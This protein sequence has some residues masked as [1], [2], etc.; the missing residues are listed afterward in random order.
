MRLIGHALLLLLALCVVVAGI[1]GGLRL[2]DAGR[3]LQPASERAVGDRVVFE[4][5]PGKPMRFNVSNHQG[6]AVLRGFVVAGVAARARAMPL[7]VQIEVLD[8]DARRLRVDRRFLELMASDQAPAPYG[9]LAGSADA[10]VWLL[11]EE[12]IDLGSHPQ[13]REIRVQPV[14]ADAAIAEV[15]WRA[16]IEARLGDDA[17]RLRY[18]RLGARRRDALTA[19]WVTPASLI[20]PQ[21]KR[22]LMRRQRQP[23]GPLGQEGTDYRVRRVLRD[24]FERQRRGYARTESREFAIGPGLRV[25]VQVSAPTSVRIRSAATAD[26]ALTL[27]QSGPEGVR[28]FA[29]I[30]LSPFEALLPAARYELRATRNGTVDVRDT[31]TGQRLA[32]DGLQTLAFPVDAKTVSSYR[33]FEAA[34]AIAPVRL[35]FRARNGPARVRVHVGDAEGQP[36]LDRE[37]LVAWQPSL[38]DRAFGDLDRPLGEPVRLTIHPPAAARV[39]RIE[40]DAEVLATV[41]TQAPALARAIDSPTPL[42]RRRWFSFLPE[43]GPSQGVIVLQ[44]PRLLGAVQRHQPPPRPGVRGATEKPTPRLRLRPDNGSDEQQEDS[45][46]PD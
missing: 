27:W 9:R 16:S 43:A 32:P 10:P 30:A 7:S 24:A 38:Y 19:D 4:A 39:L 20:A 26:D 44:Q 22:E 36:L 45:D 2:W 3:R 18:N 14:D 29:T 28:R 21:T 15:F 35:V 37:L 11:P 23:V 8:T 42:T 46:A 25:G 1:A 13:A 34:R 31:A 41:F 33:L 17:L 12:W 5:M 40:A 6:W